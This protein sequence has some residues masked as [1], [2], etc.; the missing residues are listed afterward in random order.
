MTNDAP[1]RARMTVREIVKDLELYTGRFPKRAMRAA[2]EQREAITPE[3]LRVLEEVAASP[4][5]FAARDDYMLHL[6]SMYLLAQFRETRAYR[7]L[8]AIFSAPGEIPF[9]LAGDTV[10]EGLKQLFGSVYDGDPGP[11]QGLVENNGANEYV[12]SAAI[13]AFIVLAGSG[14]MPRERVVDYYRNLF[15]GGL[16]RVAG[17]TWN[18]L[19]CA[20]ADLPAPEL[21]EDVR[22]AYADRLVDRGFADLRGV[23]RDLL[24]PNRRRRDTYSIITDAV[25]EMEG[26]SSFH[27]EGA[28]SKKPP[29]ST[30][31]SSPGA[32]PARSVKVGRNEPCPCGSGKKYKKCCGNT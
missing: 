26:W 7:P 29:G 20:A 23:E 28:L 16:E 2:I 22:K 24:D 17:Q 9:D 12:R 32:A 31:P 6:F 4:E 1:D 14:Q 25:A 10:T 15:H 21:L 5:V 27:R 18:G 3:L 8:V 19:V 13:D 11:L 30:P